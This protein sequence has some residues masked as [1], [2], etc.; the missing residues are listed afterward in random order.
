MSKGDV[1]IRFTI[2]TSPIRE[3]LIR[4][5]KLMICTDLFIAHLK[6]SRAIAASA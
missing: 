6:I 1:T 5:L 3:T 2:D 4:H